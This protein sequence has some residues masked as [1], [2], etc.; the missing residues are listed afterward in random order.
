LSE[1]QDI[2]LGDL[3]GDGLLDIVASEYGDIT[4]DFDSHTCIFINT[5]Q[6]QSFSFNAPI[7]ISGDGYEGYAQVQDINGD[8]KLD[9]IT[10]R[11]N[12][13][14]M[15]VYLN[16]TE[17][18]NVSF[19]DKVII[20]DYV[21]PR[22][23]F[24]DLNGDGMIDMVSTANT[25]NRRDVYVYLNNSTVENIDFNL[26]FVIQSG[27]EHPDGP[28]DYDWSVYSPTLA[29]I[30]G[31]G[32]LDIIV[33]NGTASFTSPSGIS[34]LRNTST[35]S[36]LGF[37]YEYSSFYQYE[38]NSLPTRI[39]ISDLNGDGK[40]DILTT[41]WLGGISI[42]VNTSTEGNIALEEQ[43]IIGV[44]NY[45][46]SIASADLNMD[47]TP[48]IVVANWEVEGMRVIHNFLSVE[49]QTNDL[50]YD[51]NND[52][53][54]N[55][56]DFVMLLSFVIGGNDSVSAADINFDSVV[57][58]FDLLLLSDFLQNM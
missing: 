46:L 48:E 31:D 16:T 53:L 4:D 30:D 22:P 26:E 21:D 20:E 42:M 56:S 12:W 10:S 38:S 49:E 57:D 33:A 39:G 45:P 18:N 32:R 37:E 7:I 34:I 27:G 5:S 3:N 8:G 50:P 55:N 9:I 41:D 52:G 36:E 19:A 23:D 54:V 51:I 6:N 28:T 11:T 2:A 15:G 44:G 1:A 13:H 40:P 43:M 25:T 24:A 58:I 29:D 14:Q 35:D 47:S 17:N